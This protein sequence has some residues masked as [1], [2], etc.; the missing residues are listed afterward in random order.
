V[1]QSR[2]GVPLSYSYKVSILVSIHSTGGEEE[3][4]VVISLFLGNPDVIY[5]LYLFS[6][7]D[8]KPA[9]FRATYISL[10]S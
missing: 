4:H 3:D 8:T 9:L 1:F 2:I 7:M 5:E 6:A 10:A